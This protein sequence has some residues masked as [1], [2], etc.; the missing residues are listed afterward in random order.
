VPVYEDAVSS[1]H[2][3]SRRQYR[4]SE[5]HSQSKDHE[6]EDSSSSTETSPVRP[7][8]TH[9]THL[10]EHVQGHIQQCIATTPSSHGLLIQIDLSEVS[11]SHLRSLDDDLEHE[12][13]DEAEAVER[14]RKRF[15]KQIAKTWKSMPS[16]QRIGT[17][18]MVL[19][20]ATVPAW[21]IGSVQSIADASIKQAK[22]SAAKAQILMGEAQR[23]QGAKSPAPSSP[24]ATTAPKAKRQDIESAANTRK[25]SIG[26][27]ITIN[28]RFDR[29]DRAGTLAKGVKV[30]ASA[31]SHVIFEFDD[32][33][34]K[35][36]KAISELL[37]G[38]SPHVPK[39]PA[40]P[41]LDRVASHISEV[42]Q[43]ASKAAAAAASKVPADHIPG[44]PIPKEDNKVVKKMLGYAGAS[45]P[46]IYFPAAAITVYNA[47]RKPETKADVSKY[48]R[49][50]AFDDDGSTFLPRVSCVPV[51]KVDGMD[52]YVIPSGSL[53]V[54]APVDDDRTDTYYAADHSEQPHLTKRDPQ[55]G[56]AAVKVV[57]K[58]AHPL[59]LLGIGTMATGI[60]YIMHRINQ[61]RELAD[62]DLDE[63][64]VRRSSS[65][66][67]DDDIRMEKRYNGRIFFAGLLAGT[68][69]SKAGFGVPKLRPNI[70]EKEK[71]DVNEQNVL[72]K[73][74]FNN[75]L[76]RVA[77]DKVTIAVAS[78][79]GGYGLIKSG[80]GGKMK[81]LVM[82]PKI[83]PADA[84]AAA[85][86]AKRALA[87]D[88][89]SDVPM[90]KRMGRGIV[91]ALGL[92]GGVYAAQ[93]TGR[94]GQEREDKQFEQQRS[95][96]KP[97]YL[98]RRSLADVDDEDVVWIRRGGE[99]KLLRNAL[100]MGDDLLRGAGKKIG[101]ALHGE[102]QALRRTASRS[103]TLQRLESVGSTSSNRG[104][105]LSR[106][107]GPSGRRYSRSISR[108][109][110]P[111]PRVKYEEV[112]HF[113]HADE[114]GT[115]ALKEAGKEGAVKG[116]KKASKGKA[117]AMVAGGAAAGAYTHH[118]Y[119]KHVASKAAEPAQIEPT[120]ADTAL[121]PAP[122]AAPPAQDITAAPS[123]EAA[124]DV[125][126]ARRAFIEDEDGVNMQKREKNVFVQRNIHHHN[127]PN[128]ASMLDTAETTL[129]K[130]KGLSVGKKVMLAFGG[131]LIGVLVHSLYHNAKVTK[132]EKDAAASQAEAAAPV[133]RR[134]LA[135]ESDD[136]TLQIRDGRS[137]MA[138]AIFG[139]FGATAVGATAYA[140]KHNN[141]G[142]RKQIT[143]PKG[144]LIPEGGGMRKRDTEVQRGATIARRGLLAK[145]SGVGKKLLGVMRA[146]N[147]KS[148]ALAVGTGLTL[149]TAAAMVEPKPAEAK[150]PQKRSLD[151][152][153][154]LQKRNPQA[155]RL[156][157]LFEPV[158][159]IWTNFGAK[160]G[161]L[162]Q[163]GM[164]VAGLSV[165]A[166]ATGMLRKRNDLQE[167][168]GMDKRGLNEK[169]IG[170]MLDIGT[171]G[172]VGGGIIRG[173][174]NMFKPKQK[175]SAVAKVPT[176]AQLGKRQ[177]VYVG[178]ARNFVLKKRSLHTDRS[179][180]RRDGK[181]EGS[182]T[183]QK[184]TDT[185]ASSS[186]E[187]TDLDKRSLGEGMLGVSSMVRR[188]PQ[189][190]IGFGA[191]KAAVHVV[192][193]VGKLLK[194]RSPDDAL[195]GSATIVKRS[196][197]EIAASAGGLAMTA[198]PLFSPV[199]KTIGKG[200]KA[201]GRGIGK[202]FHKRSLDAEPG[203]GD[204]V[205]MVQ[206]SMTKFLSNASL[207]TI[208]G[209]LLAP[210]LKSVFKKKKEKAPD[211][212]AAPAKRSLGPRK[213]AEPEYKDYVH[214][215]QKET[216]EKLSKVEGTSK[217][218]VKRAEPEKGSAAQSDPV[219]NTAPAAAPGPAE[220]STGT[221]QHPAKVETHVHSGKGEIT[222]A[223]KITFNS[224]TKA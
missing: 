39:V 161:R 11:G 49:A 138:K 183:L 55:A 189:P 146:G 123:S 143:L 6:N 136:A 115:A 66:Q 203:E 42:S 133:A 13:M 99:Q 37:H 152:L 209:S 175:V 5:G 36:G 144:A 192:G 147:K 172:V 1:T 31:A 92:A 119:T 224:E 110:A 135:V 96:V 113:Y 162:A 196:K 124:G 7:I 166:G 142:V 24:P 159:K 95:K 29:R 206:R 20:L 188:D 57:S 128:T 10:V 45:Y 217:T 145:L 41:S 150:L 153:P 8:D 194:K 67:S 80:L 212:A 104:R 53:D 3:R 131:A 222:V 19:S 118:L 83:L 174:Y 158:T 169:Q 156:M 121:A 111:E 50:E 106:G 47:R 34:I 218:I 86:V 43:T 130:S 48:R 155:G 93:R 21:L 219:V 65:A 97:E 178:H 77:T 207:A 173:V 221:F 58:V 59:K 62:D 112:H 40:S 213:R 78:M 114:A 100:S 186:G 54:D 185:N 127:L 205:R 15:V 122:M 102:G 109:P 180:K 179:M 197:L 90:Q 211:P 14:L 134:S 163:K 140:Y 60:G 26:Q 223:T 141:P 74:G 61:K 17:L 215:L 18:G 168:D 193:K 208:G 129:A 73:R 51:A 64:L 116:A 125:K 190:L 12:D 151:D 46:L 126:P 82:N 81:K 75:S 72:L 201:M 198:L 132:A 30:P 200:F 216:E 25:S 38:G 181:I 94:R 176:L 44:R 107:P 103:R 149:S 98:T 89:A 154:R 177:L 157:K 68:A 87:D 105:S 84:P 164:I 79:A 76:M 33:I 91:V 22:L 71:R 117:A 23:L 85:Q 137:V 202:V 182:N 214:A 210:V 63:T 199:A 56:P 16:E 2:G 9:V 88:D 191:V 195:E 187:V 32:L 184:R 27:D 220:K 148:T 139:L 70:V 35:G 165:G 167:D 28:I 120:V 52:D 170:H 4:E 171:L 69:L 204:D 160:H 101:S 108:K